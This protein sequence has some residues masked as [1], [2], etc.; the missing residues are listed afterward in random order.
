MKQKL[1]ALKIILSK[2][3]LL[4]GSN[5]HTVLSIRRLLKVGVLKK[6]T[7]KVYDAV[8]LFNYKD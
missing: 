2:E 3:L 1:R 7:K 8:M 4:A 6:N 5:M